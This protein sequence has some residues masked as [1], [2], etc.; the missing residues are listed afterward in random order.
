MRRPF[1]SL[2]AIAILSYWFMT[3]ITASAQDSGTKLR[4]GLKYSTHVEA[5]GITVG[6]D[7]PV[8]NKIRAGGDFNYYIPGD[9]GG[10][11]VTVWTINVNGYYEVLTSDSMT[12]HA[13]AGINYL[14]WSYDNSYCDSFFFGLSCDTTFTDTGLNLGGLAEFGT[15]NVGFFGTV[16]IVGLGGDSNGLVIGGGVSYGL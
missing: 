6:G 2:F 9:E 1:F 7:L 13:L 14:N 5:I 3:P 4:G 8:A 10:A 12:I 16:Q 11:S 15:G